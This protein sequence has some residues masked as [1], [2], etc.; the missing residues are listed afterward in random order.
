MAIVSMAVV[1]LKLGPRRTLLAYRATIHASNGV[2]PFEILTG[3]NMTVPFDTLLPNK[4]EEV[5]HAPWCA[6][7][8]KKGVRKTLDIA[9]G[10]LEMSDGKN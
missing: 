3:R 5:D 2:V 7:R 6:L 4:E 9:R 1:C 10:N 8:L